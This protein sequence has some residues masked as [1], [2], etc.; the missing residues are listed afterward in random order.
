MGVRGEDGFQG[1]GHALV[2]GAE[3]GEGCGPVGDDLGTRDGRHGG[4]SE[5]AF[6][7]PK[8]CAI[9]VIIARRMNVRKRVE[10]P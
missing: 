6:S 2:G 3:L 8:R 4:V 7:E 10:K 9:S 1:L 5:R